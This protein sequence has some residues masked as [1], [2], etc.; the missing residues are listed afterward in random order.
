MRMH[1]RYAAIAVVGF[2]VSFAGLV[3][4]DDA[5]DRDARIRDIDSQLGS[6]AYDLRGAAGSGSGSSE[7]QSARSR[8]QQ[9]KD[10][11]SQL[12][13]VKGSDSKASNYVSRYPRYVEDFDRATQALLQIKA[14][15]RTLTDL[16]RRCQDLDRQ[17]VEQANR[18][19]QDKDGERIEEL[20]RLALDAGGKAEDWWRDADRK[21]EEMTRWGDDAR[22][23]S[24]SDDAW[25]SVTSSLG[26]AVGRSLEAWMKELAE[27]ERACKD[28]RQK[29]RHPAIERVLREFAGTAK[30]KDAIY[31][32]LDER[33]KRAEAAIKD[34]VSSSSSDKVNEA[35]GAT[36]EVER[37]VRE[38]DG[39][40]GTDRKA[41]AIA[42]QWPDIVRAFAPVA[43]ALQG[44]KD[45]QFQLDGV[46]AK[47]EV[48]T[49]ELTAQLKKY[50]DDK[51][52]DGLTDGPKLADAAGDKYTRAIA[53]MEAARSTLRGLVSTAG[54][55][56][57]RD[58]RWSPLKRQVKDTADRIYEYWDKKTQEVHGKCDDLAKGPRNPAIERFMVELGGTTSSELKTF[59]DVMA[60]WERDAR[61]IYVLDCKDMQELWDAWCSVEFEPNEDPEIGPVAQK[62]AE[63]IDRESQKIDG[64]L[65]RLGP[66]K[67]TARKLGAKAKYRDAIAA[68]NREIE[69]Q[70]TRLEKLKRKNG[71]WRGNNNPALQFTKTFGQQAHDRKARDHSCNVYD[72]PGYPGLGRDRPDCVVVEGGNACLVYEFKPK[73]WVGKDKLTDYHRAVTAYYTRAMRT[74]EAPASNLGGASFQALVEANCRADPSKDKKDDVIRFEYRYD[75]YDRCEHRYQ[76]SE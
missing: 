49:H 69:K 57:A 46:P 25:S 56:E 39:V 33:L 31:Q 65:A 64:V 66:I 41:T 71:D 63:V 76:C 35:R 36:G 60:V 55:F 54:A 48:S 26:E 43:T 17:L 32:Q 10:K 73:D 11:L 22:R 45:V 40:K 9:V 20:R 23:F 68:I 74:G 37:L 58:D 15:Q 42:S 3:V 13:R 50:V 62:T 44:L 38:L 29:D 18:F 51:D 24:V 12:D 61:D 52:P 28:L 53:G 47:C 19:A 14:N 21:R 67:D 7:V 8:V 27:S 1:H 16:P 4:A 70:Q 72:Q 2:V 75:S 5:S 30:G 34:L 6:A 59:Q